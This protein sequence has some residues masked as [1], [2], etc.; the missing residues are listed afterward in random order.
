MG[1]SGETAECGMYLIHRQEE[2]SR[3]AHVGSHHQSR[4]PQAVR[5]EGE[6][7]AVC[8]V[9]TPYRCQQ[10]DVVDPPR[11]EVQGQIPAQRFGGNVSR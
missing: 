1:A 2:I 9:K 3:P 7:P 8:Q 4:C 6:I 10:P 11:G 5:V